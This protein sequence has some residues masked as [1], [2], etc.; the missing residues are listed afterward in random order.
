[1]PDPFRDR[2]RAV[3]QIIRTIV[4]H[5]HRARRDRHQDRHNFPEACVIHGDRQDVPF[6][7]V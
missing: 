3:Y 7:G 2:L 1:M 4:S 6:V 5:G